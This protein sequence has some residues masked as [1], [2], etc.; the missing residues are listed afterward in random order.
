MR[1]LRTATSAPREIWTYGYDW[2]ARESSTFAGE[3]VFVLSRAHLVQN[4]RA[5]GRP[6]DLA[7]VA[8]LESLDED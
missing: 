8:A 4:K 1:W 7:D 5:S 3:P 2:P 6:Q